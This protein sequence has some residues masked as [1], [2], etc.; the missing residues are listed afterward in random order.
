VRFYKAPIPRST[1][2]LNLRFLPV[3]TEPK[4]VG[5]GAPSVPTHGSQLLIARPQGY[6]S[7]ERDPVLIDNKIAT[8]EPAGL[9]LN[10][11]FL[12]NLPTPPTQITTV[13]LRKETIAARPSADL[14]KDLPVVDFLW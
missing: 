9:P 2:L 8:D 13:A 4:V 10:D 12:A 5:Q 6:F 11:A 7:R 1:A 3:P 14:A